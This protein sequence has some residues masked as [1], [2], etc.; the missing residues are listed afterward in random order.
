[1]FSLTHHKQAGTHKPGRFNKSSCI[2]QFLVKL[3]TKESTT[4]LWPLHWATYFKGVGCRH[5]WSSQLT[6]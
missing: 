4:P 2:R 3:A 1:M 6:L 5:E